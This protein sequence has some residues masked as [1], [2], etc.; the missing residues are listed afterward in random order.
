MSPWLLLAGATLPWAVPALVAWWY[1]GP[2]DPPKRPLRRSYDLPGP[3][4]TGEPR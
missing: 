3:K 1:D 4:G 2:L